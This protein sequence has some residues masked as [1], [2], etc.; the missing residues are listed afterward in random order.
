MACS[1][2]FCGTRF[3]GNAAIVLPTKLVA[4]LTVG[5]LQNVLHHELVHFSKKRRLA[6]QAGNVLF[7]PFG[8][9]TPVSWSAH[10]RLV[11]WEEK[12]VDAALVADSRSSTRDYASVL[13]ATEE[14]VYQGADVSTELVPA[15]FQQ[16]SL[17]A[18]IEGHRE[19]GSLKR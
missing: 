10:R 2:R 15:L 7:A 11:D 3:L 8:G 18:R 14:F 1:P 5:E 12:R 16:R 17:H 9:G 19:W 4:Q 13:L 6:P